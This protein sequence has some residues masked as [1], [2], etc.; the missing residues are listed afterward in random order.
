MTRVRTEF[1]QALVIIRNSRLVAGQGLLVSENKTK[2]LCHGAGG[3]SVPM[4]SGRGPGFKCS[5]RH[6]A[7]NQHPTLIVTRR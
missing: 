3:G 1:V 6:P 4:L 7:F 2:L 5:E